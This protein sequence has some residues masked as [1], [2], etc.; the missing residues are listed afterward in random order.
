MEN[1]VTVAKTEDIPVGKSIVV[2]E[3]GEEIALFN[4]DGTLYACSNRCPHAGGPLKDSMIAGTVL[5]CPWHGWRFDLAS[6]PD[7]PKDG[8]LRYPVS[9][10]GD[11]IVL[12]SATT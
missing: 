4:I 11:D 3:H 5:S 8:V 7:A 12:G 10:E 9:V 6:G 2:K 1:G